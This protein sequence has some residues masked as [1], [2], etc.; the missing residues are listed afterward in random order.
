V[1][2]DMKSTRGCVA[3]NVGRHGTRRTRQSAILPA[4]GPHQETRWLARLVAASSMFFSLGCG[5]ESEVI[6]SL[7]IDPSRV[8]DALI[9]DARSGMRDGKIPSHLR[10]AIFASSDPQ[11]QRAGRLLRAIDG[12][13]SGE[14]GARESGLEAREMETPRSAPLT[15]TGEAERADPTRVGRRRDRSGVEPTTVAMAVVTRMS[16]H[17]RP[18]NGGVFLDFRA[19]VPVVLSVVELEEGATVQIIL[20]SSGILPAAR[21]SRPSTAGV[22]V[23]DVRRGDQTVQVRIALDPGWVVDGS[24]STPQGA[25]VQFLE[26][27]HSTSMPD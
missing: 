18:K 2:L 26:R 10:D 5:G 14:V 9:G 11:H 4:M 20:R 16:L 21:S 22:T 23:T 6:G 17:K 27:G 25:T 8:G 24:R 13:F 19:A 12:D 15:A 7:P 3:Q 1:R